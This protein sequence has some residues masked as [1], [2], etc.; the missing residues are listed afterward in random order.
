MPLVPTGHAAHDVAPVSAS[1]N[2]QINQDFF[3]EGALT[4]LILTCAAAVAARLAL[5]VLILPG[6]ANNSDV[7]CAITV[8]S[9]RAG[10][11]AVGAVK[12]CAANF[13]CYQVRFRANDI[14]SGRDARRRSY[15][16]Y[17]GMA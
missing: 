13:A 6:G 3:E 17:L 15:P 4:G 10:L 14:I 7:A 2:H 16:T 9:C 8:R 11:A 12:S 5:L 1:V